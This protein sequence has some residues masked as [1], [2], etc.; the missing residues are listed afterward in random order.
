[1][2]TLETVGRVLSS[3]SLR[4]HCRILSVRLL[5]AAVGISG[6]GCHALR[7]IPMEREL[8]DFTVAADSEFGQLGLVKISRRSVHVQNIGR[9][10]G[11]FRLSVDVL[12]SMGSLLLQAAIPRGD[13]MIHLSAAHLGG[14]EGID[15]P[16]SQITALQEIID[17]LSS[18]NSGFGIRVRIATRDGEANLTNSVGTREW[19]PWIFLEPGKRIATH[20]LF[21]FDRLVRPGKVSLEA[22]RIPPAFGIERPQQEDSILTNTDTYSRELHLT[23]PARI[24][25]GLA[26]AVRLTVTDMGTSEIRQQHL[27]IAV[28]DTLPPQVTGYRAI[29]GYDGAVAIQVSA[30]DRQ[31]GVAEN[32]VTTEYSTDGGSTWRRK[33]HRS[34]EDTFG[35]PAIFESIIGPFAPGQG[36]LL[37]VVVADRVGNRTT[38]IPESAALFAAPRTLAVSEQKI[39][40][41]AEGSPLFRHEDLARIMET[42]ESEATQR[43]DDF[44][45]ARIRPTD[46]FEVR[47]KLEWRALFSTVYP[48]GDLFASFSPIEVIRISDPRGLSSRKN[49]LSL[50]AWR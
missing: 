36:V 44:S 6:L 38:S 33:V 24:P 46:P 13:S 10:P 39:G 15:V 5:R 20:F 22:L 28:N 16:F 35:R 42:V 47:R 41:M 23:T 31:S 30:A 2:P 32:A 17:T 7:P 3:L 18:K 8:P 14:R 45:R 4:R 12:D 34:V 27:R 25:H 19:R 50:A 9:A 1:M 49:L 43:F 26:I 21:N 37:G 48:E 40:A 29:L 11:S